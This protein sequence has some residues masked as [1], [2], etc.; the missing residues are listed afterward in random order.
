MNLQ[1]VKFTLTPEY[2]QKRA[3]FLRVLHISPNYTAL[4]PFIGDYKR[5][6]RQHG[7]IH[8]LMARFLPPHMMEALPRACRAARICDVEDISGLPG[9]AQGTLLIHVGTGYTGAAIMSYHLHEQSAGFD[10]KRGDYLVQLPDCYMARSKER[11]ERDFEPD[12]S[13]VQKAL[14]DVETLVQSKLGKG[15]VD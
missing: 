15:T 11:F 8:R 13:D 10:V 12:M 1:N 14:E 7:F 6:P 9:F 2:L 3:D 4:H 5:K